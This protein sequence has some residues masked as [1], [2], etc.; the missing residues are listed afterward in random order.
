MPVF[1]IQIDIIDGERGYTE[2]EL[3][4]AEEEGKAE[5]YARELLRNYYDEP[6]A[7]FVDSE[8]GVYLCEAWSPGDETCAQIG[9]VRPY[10]P[11]LLW[12]IDRKKKVEVELVVKEDNYA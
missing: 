12:D 10:K 6:G 11:G 9:S 4:I 5:E 1:D 7:R 3:V 8:E 2:H